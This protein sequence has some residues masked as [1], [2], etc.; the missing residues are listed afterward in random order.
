MNPAWSLLTMQRFSCLLLAARYSLLACFIA[1]TTPFHAS[2]QIEPDRRSTLPTYQ[3][4]PGTTPPVAA[5]PVPCQTC[6]LPQQRA[7][8]NLP[9]HRRRG[10]KGTHPHKR[11]RATHRLSQRSWRSF[12]P[13]YA[14]ESLTRHATILESRQIRVVDGDTFRYG[15]Q[16]IRIRGIDAPELSEPGGLNA[17][18]RLEA[19]LTQG[20][21]HMIPRGK[22][23]YDRLVADVF[24]DGQNVAEL[25]A[26]EGYA[27]PRQ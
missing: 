3:L 2:A 16:R 7:T 19:L 18:K 4:S 12:L 11:P 10:L 1:V 25:L 17:A 5:S 21:V 6:W 20:S 24:I 14:T 27:K 22:D 8:T 13:R 26:R 9:Y 15:F 23:V